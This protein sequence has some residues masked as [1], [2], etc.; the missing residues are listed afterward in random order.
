MDLDTDTGMDPYNMIELKVKVIIE[1]YG[2]VHTEKFS[3]FTILCLPQANMEQQKWFRMECLVQILKS[4][5]LRCVKQDI[6]EDGICTSF[7]L[8]I[9]TAIF[10]NLFLIVV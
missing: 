1:I 3:R 10:I 9:L 2:W 6:S 5:K 4:L 7:F 8:F